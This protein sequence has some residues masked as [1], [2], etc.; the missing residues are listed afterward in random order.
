MLRRL[1]WLTVGAGFGFGAS[2]WVTRRVRERIARY[3]PQRMSSDM[4]QAVRGFSGDVRAAVSEGREAMRAREVELRAK[5]EA[6]AVSGANGAG[7][8]G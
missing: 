5:V 2:F 1:F 7:A 6:G 8:A 4:A 3:T